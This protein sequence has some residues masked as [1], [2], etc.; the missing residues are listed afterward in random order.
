MRPIEFRQ[1][2]N[3]RKVMQYGAGIVKD[4]HWHGF[5][6]VTF[7]EDPIMQFTG[8]LDK[9]GKKIYEGD[10]LSFSGLSK[11]HQKPFVIEWIEKDARFSDYSPK[12]QAEVIGNI[13]ENEELLK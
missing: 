9:N 12:N 8:L 4:G 1:W 2:L 3:K 7:S 6:S 10:I 13:Y 11:F 5:S